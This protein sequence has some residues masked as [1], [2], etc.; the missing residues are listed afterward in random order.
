MIAQVLPDHCPDAGQLAEFFEGRIDG[1]FDRHIAVCQSCVKFLEQLECQAQAPIGVCASETVQQGFEEYFLRCGL[2]ESAET[3][4]QEGPGAP[5]PGFQA[6]LL[7]TSQAERYVDRKLIGRGSFADVYSAWDTR[8]QIQV[9]LKV[10][11]PELFASEQRLNDFMQEARC[12]AKLDHPGLVPVRDVYLDFGRPAIVLKLVDG[13]SLESRLKRGSLYAVKSVKMMT[14]IARA[15]HHAHEANLIHC[16]LKP[17]NILLDKNES[18]AVGDFGVAV[19]LQEL[20][21]SLR[22]RD[23]GGTYRYMSPEHHAHMNRKGTLPPLAPLDRRSDVWALGVMLAEMLQGRCPFPQTDKAELFSAVRTS[24]PEL[25]PNLDRG[26]AAMIQ[27][28]LE[29]KSVDRFA[30]ADELA[31]GLVQWQQ[32]RDNFKQK[33]RWAILSLVVLMAFFLIA[34]AQY[35]RW[36]TQQTLG[37]LIVAPSAQVANLIA[38]LV[39]RKVKPKS[40]KIDSDHP[41]LI[42]QLR[43][44]IARVACGGGEPETWSELVDVL[45]QLSS[46]KEF[47]KEFEGEL[48]GV[49]SSLRPRRE[50]PACRGFVAAAVDRLR[51]LPADK[52]PPAIKKSLGLAAI[53]AELGDDF[54]VCTER[55]EKVV[56]DLLAVLA[57]DEPKYLANFRSIG[58]SHLLPELR[59]QAQ[60]PES[61]KQQQQSD[62]QRAAHA[63]RVFLMEQVADNESQRVS[64]LETLAQVVMNVDWDLVGTLVEFDPSLSRNKANGTLEYPEYTAQQR[65]TLVGILQQRFDELATIPRATDPKDLDD[66]APPTETDLQMARLA[67]ALWQLGNTA[68]ANSALRDEPDPTLKTQFIFGLARQQ[69]NLPWLVQE[70]EQRFQQGNNESPALFGLLQ[71]LWLIPNEHLASTVNREWLDTLWLT[72]ADTGVHAMA[73]L[74][75]RKLGATPTPLTPGSYGNWRVEKVGPLQIELAVISKQAFTGGISPESTLHSGNEALPLYRG[76]IERDYA[77]GLQEVTYQQYREFERDFEANMRGEIAIYNLGDQQVFAFCNWCSRQQGL[78]CCYEIDEALRQLIPRVDYQKL[79]GYRLPTEDE[80]ECAC[81]AGTITG[82]F[83]GQNST[84]PPINEKLVS[85][86]FQYGWL[87]GHP[88]LEK[89]NKWSLPVCQLLPN[90][91]GLFDIYGNVRELCSVLNHELRPDLEMQMVMVQRSA[92]FSETGAEFAFSHARSTSIT[93]RVVTGFR[94]ART[95]SESLFEH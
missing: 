68:A 87:S 44:G 90:R 83:F 67:V 35:Q 12:A 27:R 1:R 80:W 47:E 33:A 58:V 94:L 31:N 56:Q 57:I 85:Q 23:L 36:K 70:L 10:L 64:N 14:Q 59:R 73:G 86:F 53:I 26:L 19:D 50:S 72:S 15:V 13:E 42:S 40:L 75:L 52:T 24:Q 5:R 28:C 41:S 37:D 17:A 77:I 74:L 48:A 84:S 38:E 2:V 76:V 88:R 9:A 11:R 69:L 39:K 49:I 32:R 22:S 66:Q 45:Q 82:R 62:R 4:T 51:T 21:E 34:P 54:E 81:R 55:N 95:L 78:D 8:L 25:D 7:E 43:L 92:S 46:E 91:W 65:A 61:D 71:V 60:L 16:D 93:D 29:K 3:V 18:P 63:I 30:S 6:N 79:N 89:A 20:S